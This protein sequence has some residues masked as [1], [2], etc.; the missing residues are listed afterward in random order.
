MKFFSKALGKLI[1]KSVIKHFKGLNASI[2][3]PDKRQIH[4]SEKQDALTPNMEVLDWSFFVDLA[5]GYD[6]GFAKAYLNEKWNCNDLPNL[7]KQLSQNRLNGTN[8]SIGNLLPV[9]LYSKFVQQIKSKNSIYWSKRNI[10]DHYDLS[11]EFF[12]KILDPSMTYSCAVFKTDKTNLS[13]AQD[14]K[15][16]LLLSKSNIHDKSHILDI[17]CGWGGLLTKAVQ[18]YNCE[19]TGVTLSKSQFEYCTE[20]VDRLGLSD[21]IRILFQD[22][23]TLKGNFDQIYSV[24]MLEAVGHTGLKEFFRKCDSLLNEDGTLS[25]Q[26]IT[27]PDERYESYRKNCDYIQKYI[28][29]GGMLPSMSSITE[30]A[31]YANN[32]VIQDNLSIG[33]HYE[34]TLR[35][36][37]NNLTDSS[38]DI[39]RL[40]FSTKDI[41]RFYYYFS[42]CEGGFAAKYIDDLQLL[43]RKSANVV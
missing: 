24:E 8:I 21:R 33:K 17:G 15:I 35:I 40:G 4:L 9:K 2:T 3:L 22:Y 31:C 6:L 39:L 41:R 30:S 5:T 16:R 28:F 36:W 25:I 32:F 26:V 34:Q 12:Q 14:E 23:R 43:L 38:N 29:P 42:Y 37:R 19:G 18:E 11:N 13:E 10:R 27:I 20:L 7:F 1:Y